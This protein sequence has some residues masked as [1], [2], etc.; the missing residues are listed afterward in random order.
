M[1]Q[2]KSDLFAD[3]PFCF[4]LVPFAGLDS[5]L[6]IGQRRLSV[7]NGPFSRKRHCRRR[8]GLTMNAVKNGAQFS[9]RHFSHRTVKLAV[10][11]GHG[12]SGYSAE[13]LQAT[14]SL[15]KL[16]LVNQ[17]GACPMNQP[18]TNRI[19]AM[20]VNFLTEKFDIPAEDATRD[21]ALRDLGL[22]SMLVLDVILEAED[23]LG[24]KLDDLTIPRNATLSDVAAM[25]QRNLEA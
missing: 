6:L 20:L 23:R 14:A 25:I 12:E 13:Y 24:V 5:N 11:L 8:A 1:Q 7:G 17:W 2:E 10:I 15:F 19:L 21:V 3:F 9:F 22:D 18:D 16:Q 4:M